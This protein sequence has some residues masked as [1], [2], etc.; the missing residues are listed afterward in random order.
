MNKKQALPFAHSFSSYDNALLIEL[1]ND[2]EPKT[3]ATVFQQSSLELKLLILMT[4]DEER[5]TYL[6]NQLSIQERLSLKEYIAS[7]KMKKS[8]EEIIDEYGENAQLSYKWVDFFLNE[9]SDTKKELIQDWLGYEADTAGRIMHTSYIKVS[10]GMTLAQS[11]DYIKEKGA[12]APIYTIY[13]VDDQNKLLGVLSLRDIIL[14]PA[15]ELISNVMNKSVYK[16]TTDTDQEEVANLLQQHDFL[17]IPVVD[18]ENT[19][20]GVVSVDQ[21]MD[22]LQEEATDDMFN[23]AGIAE[24]KKNE[25]DRSQVLVDGSI[26]EIW[27]V[28]MPFLIITL[29]GGLLAGSVVGAFEE[30]LE[31]VVAVAVFIPIIM[32]MGGNV[33]TQ[34]STVF[35]RGVILGHIKME[36]IWKHLRKEVLMGLSMGVAVGAV[37]GIV[38]YFWQGIPELGLA[39]ALALVLTM[40][41]GTFLGFI[42]PYVLIKLNLDQAA[43][44]DPIITSIKDVTGLLI[45]FFLVQLLL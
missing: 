29:L 11:L 45:Y 2:A 3:L 10:S 21:G 28:R 19:L 35:A 15:T 13:V 43:G 32:D 39:I 40:M 25:T 12:Y 9:N 37:T 42:V 18:K 34:S 7:E 22:I 24:L 20:L 5:T 16:V 23:Q 17:S 6:F 1:M 31:A 14:A 26:W 8:F 44:T 36:N 38:A 4:L 33:G 41:L 27:K 30:T